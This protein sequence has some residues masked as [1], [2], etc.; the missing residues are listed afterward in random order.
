MTDPVHDLLGDGG[1]HPPFAVDGPV[2][3]SVV[4]R[5]QGN[6]PNSLVEALESLADQTHAPHQVLLMVHADEA[7]VVEAVR[8]N[9][10]AATLGLP[11]EISAVPTGV[12]TAPLN[13]G[14][15]AATGDYVCFLDDDDLARPDW[16]AAFDLAIQQ[17]PGRIARARTGVQPW[18]TEGT[19]EP[20]HPQGRVEE[21]FA[22]TFDLLAHVSHNETPICSIAV[23]LSSLRHHGIRFADD[24]PVL[25]DWDF[26]MQIA[27]LTGV[28][29]INAQTSLYRQLDEANAFAAES[30]ETWQQAHARVIDR[31]SSRPL[32][33][34]PGTARRVASAHFAPDGGSRHE[35]DLA[36]L[37]TEIDQ[38]TR[39]PLRWG[40]RFGARMTSAV[41][42]R[43]ARPPR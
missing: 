41:R 20:K 32:L 22:A 2:R 6:R 27:P 34:P 17:N 36:E 19:G 25:E 37:A 3:F 13:A 40:R 10:D 21:P 23:P 43:I 30:V 28:T 16:L 18:S 29:S 11:V 39:S 24:L 9:V 8:S 14:L 38:L 4:V 1:P 33:L 31:M 26:L 12:R 5:T 42:A 35:H 15:E 7:K